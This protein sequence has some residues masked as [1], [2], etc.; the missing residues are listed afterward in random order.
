MKRI[1]VTGAFGFLGA[2]FVSTL[3]EDQ[4]GSDSSKE[5]VE[6]V[7]FASKSR[8]NPLF[9]PAE[10]RVES[11]DI[12]DY[13]DMARKFQG[14]DEVVHF[15]GRVDY[16]TSMKKAVWETDVIG[17][18]N[19]FD[20]ALAAGVSKLLYASSICALGNGKPLEGAQPGALPRADETS[21]PLRRSPL[22]D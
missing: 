14:L 12:L 13:E 2:N 10:V 16:R 19:V 11:L 4:R 9:N 15:A 1:G 17:T 5:E 20:A 21:L 7:A 6:I 18:K 22:A 8:S 3:L